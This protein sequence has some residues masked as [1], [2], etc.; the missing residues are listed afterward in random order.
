MSGIANVLEWL[1]QATHRV[2]GIPGHVEQ[3]AGHQ[4]RTAHGR[5]LH[6][7]PPHG[8]SPQLPAAHHRSWNHPAR[9]PR[10]LGGW[11]RRI[12]AFFGQ[13]LP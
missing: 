8:R 9:Q 12:A 10:V 1:H 11:Q 6:L 3:P 2:P 5:S 7:S 4:G 13:Q